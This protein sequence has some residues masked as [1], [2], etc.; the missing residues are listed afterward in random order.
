M[1][2]RDNIPFYILAVLTALSVG[3]AYFRFIVVQ[4][5]IVEF[6]GVC[7][8]SMQSCFIKCSD[9]A[10]TSKE[11]YD[12]VKK[13]AANLYTQCGK[14]ITD[15]A[16]ANVCLPQDDQKCSIL[17]CDPKTDGSTCSTPSGEFGTTAT[18][19]NP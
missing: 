13:Y 18:S 17:Y 19:T 1:K 12:K 16:D 2:F 15:C 10:C 8:P 3:A 5:Y 14:D 9:D 6:E 4:D 11:Y 7:E